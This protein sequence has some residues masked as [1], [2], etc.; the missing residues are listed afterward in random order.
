MMVD[1]DTL[2][3]LKKVDGD[4]LVE[5]LDELEE[6]NE[7]YAIDKLWDGLHFL[8]T[9]V[10]ASSPIEGNKLSEAIV[11]VNLFETDDDDFASYTEKDEL[12]EICNS[13]KNVNIRELEE[14]FD[15]K[16]FKKEK[17]YPN[18]WETDKRDELFKELINEYNGLLEFY[19]KALEKNAHIVFS[20]F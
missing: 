16:T 9:G 13:M 2:D 8:L 19:Q 12:L 4:E 18:I 15:P 17:I 3:K 6:T 14:K 11:G 7:I 20:V 5:E 10:S 1:Q